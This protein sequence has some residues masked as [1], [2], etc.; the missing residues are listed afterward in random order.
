M[1]DSSIPPVGDVPS[2]GE[3]PAAAPTGTPPP[4][5]PAV[6]MAL[7]EWPP[8]PRKSA[9]KRILLSLVV[10]V[11][12]GS[13]VVNVLLGG[14]L[15]ATMKMG[16][17]GG[18]D[19][20]VI[21]KGDSDQVIALVQINN[22]I[23]GQQVAIID[24]FCRE[25]ATDDNVRAVVLRV[26]SPGGVV[27]SCDQIYHLLKD[28]KERHGKTL[29]V[30]MGGVAASGGYYIS[31]PADHIYAEPTTVTG[32]IGVIA[33]WPV[34][35]GTLEMIGVKMMVI[36][37]AQARAWKASPNL[38]EDAA[39]YQMAEVQEALNSAHERFEGIVRTE[40]GARLTIRTA[41]NTYTGADGKEFTVEE[42]EPFNGRIYPADKA[43]E[44]GLV[45]SIGYL[46]DALDEAAR[47]A[48]LVKPKVV[49]YQMRT[50]VLLRPSLL[51]AESGLATEVLDE[52]QTPRLMLL[53]KVSP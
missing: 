19:K 45:D 42:T 20:A 37:S 2:A 11:L 44:L 31:A 12:L 29:V 10:I 33:S 23:R 30:S 16:F 41:Q 35:K 32:S 14:M 53:W 47:R 8:P 17:R 13:L 21:R 43:K 48:N 5:A 22:V 50:G 6:A 36:R 39:G 26:E 1:S 28:L 18:L 25:V 15:A 3:T 40:R 52:I 49:R 51:G 27:S 9:A 7:P 38:F 46:S 24:A 4:A 34:F